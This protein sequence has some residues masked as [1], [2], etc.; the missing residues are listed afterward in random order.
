VKLIKPRPVVIAVAL[1]VTAAMSG[2]GMPLHRIAEEEA[3]KRAGF[4]RVSRTTRDEVV[5]R[6]GPPGSAFE[7]GRI[8]AYALR[9]SD[10]KLQLAGTASP[11]FYLMLVYSPEGVVVRRS[12]VQTR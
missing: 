6:L 8:V 11:D 4:V 2:C 7:D 5:R 10:G 12:L 3:A 1:A 9:D